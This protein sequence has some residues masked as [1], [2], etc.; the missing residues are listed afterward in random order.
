VSPVKDTEK[1]KFY[2]EKDYGTWTQ[3]SLMFNMRCGVNNFM[4]RSRGGK[5]DKIYLFG[6]GGDSITVDWDNRFSS[7][8]IDRV[9]NWN[10]FVIDLS[11]RD[12]IDAIEK[13]KKGNT[14]IDPKY[15]D[16][17]ANKT[18]EDI[19]EA[20]A[21]E[22]K[23]RREYL[24][25]WDFIEMFKKIID[26]GKY[27]KSNFYIAGNLTFNYNPTNGR[28]YQT[29][30]PNRIYLT[31]RE[32]SAEAVLELYYDKDSL[33]ESTVN[34]GYY[35]VNGAVETYDR[36]LKEHVYAP[37]TIVVKTARDDD[38]LEKKK[39]EHQISRF[40]N[41]KGEEVFELGMLVNLLNG[42]QRVELTEDDLTEEQ[43]DSLLFGEITWNDIYRDMGTTIWGDRVTQNVFV[44]PSRGYTT[45]RKETIITSEMLDISYFLAKAEEES[46]EIN[47]NIFE[48]EDDDLFA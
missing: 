5:M 37:Y 4:L 39:V 17:I 6:K 16:W 47:D 1:M 22:R 41:I 7:K 46:E 2:E 18:A 15:L 12:F 8:E 9:A 29:Y 48:D 28:W 10:K 44:K 24:A 38:E 3:R 25:A 20:L 45:G 40:K 43:R 34:E 23:K 11:N 33:D 19:D 21:K 42:S 27:E 31:E 35:T 30:E 32:P 13:Y 14:D 26:S 36:N